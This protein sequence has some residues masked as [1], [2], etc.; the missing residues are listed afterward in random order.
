[1]AHLVD[2]AA[3]PS[4]GGTSVLQMERAGDT[5]WRQGQK[6][7][8]QVFRKVNLVMRRVAELKTQGS[9]VLTDAA[10]AAA[11]DQERTDLGLT[12]SGYIRH[13]EVRAAAANKAAKAAA[14]RQRQ[15]REGGGEGGSPGGGEGS[16]AGSA[17]AVRGSEAT[18]PVGAG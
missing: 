8:N 5:A 7:G 15:Q 2:W 10:A 13:L 9:R 14:R 4:F 3:A 17:D 11:A 6:H 16:S 18:A 1:V 12:I